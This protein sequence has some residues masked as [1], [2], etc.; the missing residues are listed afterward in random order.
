MYD[1]NHIAMCLNAHPVGN[2]GG[3]SYLYL[4]PAIL[5]YQRT[6]YGKQIRKDYE[7]GK[8]KERR[9]NMRE[10]TIRTD[11]CSNTITTVQKDN[12]VVVDCAMRDR[13][14]SDKKQNKNRN[15]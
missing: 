11:G 13:Y 5:K 7:A 3:Y 6:E 12:Y 14:N 10:Y 1:A 9:C 2:A 4:I 8:I 15:Q